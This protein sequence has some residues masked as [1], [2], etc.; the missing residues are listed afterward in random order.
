MADERSLMKLANDVPFDDRINHKASLDD[1]QPSLIREYLVDVGSDLAKE[2]P[3]MDLE[4]LCRRMNIAEGPKEFLNR[5]IS[6]SCFLA[7]IPRNFSSS[8]N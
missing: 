1:L 7:I 6:D 4:D 2:A 8:A 3:K 5:K